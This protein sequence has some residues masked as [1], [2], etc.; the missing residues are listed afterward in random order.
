MD[1]ADALAEVMDE[2]RPYVLVSVTGGQLE[3]LFGGDPEA[4]PTWADV[5]ALL[6]YA[7]QCATT[8]AEEN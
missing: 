1:L 2:G 7:A 6:A 3:I 5:A 4:P 8:N